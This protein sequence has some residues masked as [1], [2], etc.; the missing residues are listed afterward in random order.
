MKIF[1]IKSIQVKIILCTVICTA[2][3]GITSNLYLYNYLN[4]IIATKADNIDTMYLD[5]IQQQLNRSFTDARFVLLSAASNL[6]ITTVLSQQGNAS[7]GD[8]RRRITAGNV[9]TDYLRG[10]AFDKHVYKLMAFND[11]GAVVQ[12]SSTRNGYYS[13]VDV[14]LQSEI[15]A[16]RKNYSE[17]FAYMP[18]ISPNGGMCFAML[19][20]VYDI[21]TFGKEAYVYMELNPSIVTDT[22]K[23]YSQINS[24]FA[25]TDKGDKILAEYTAGV[26]IID[27]L[28]L[29]NTG[30]FEAY[31]INNTVFRITT[32]KLNYSD[33]SI[34]NCVD[35][36][37]LSIDGRRM[38]YTLIVVLFSVVVVS[39]GILIIVSNFITRPLKKLIAHIRRMSENDFSTNPE[40]ETSQDEI[41]EVGKVIN[42]TC[43]SFKH[44]LGETVEASEQK[45][46][47]EIALLQSQVNPHFLYN[48]LDSIH[49]MA[50]IQKNPGIS[51]ITRSLSNLLKNMAKGYSQKITIEEELKLLDDYVTIQSIRYMETFELVNNIDKRFYKYNIV[52]LTLQPIVENAIFHGI[53][54]SGKFG[55]ITLSATDDDRFICISVEDTGVGMTKTEVAAVMTASREKQSG[56]SMNGIGVANVNNRLA[57]VYG[58]NCGLSIES[59]K[60]KFTRVTVRILKEEL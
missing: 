27:K 33:L 49:W 55:T 60:G 51:N 5:T 46:N 18:S 8:M 38:A 41:G 28:N 12:A 58:A 59:E 40:I 13:D 1:N 10:S 3:V 17:N 20:P 2:A 44:L 4:D 31:E 7:A 11:T 57:L 37:A 39:M 35:V 56:N 30:A 53:E 36:T 48:T 14:I 24:I 42:E 15:Y 22:L 26:D 50:V 52:K 16:R 29:Q 6:D 21:T 23:S 34:Y 43:L 47:I 25:A 19:L 54:P 32:R 9:L 45:K